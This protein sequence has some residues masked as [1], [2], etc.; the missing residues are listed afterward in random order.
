MCIRCEVRRRLAVR[1]RN[2]AEVRGAIAANLRI[3]AA[4]RACVKVY[5]DSKGQ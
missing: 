3:V 1:N 2:T 5:L 4:Q